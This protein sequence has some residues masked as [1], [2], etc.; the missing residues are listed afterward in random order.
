MATR[1]PW[2]SSV[3]ITATLQLSHSR[4]H[5]NESGD[6]I[7]ILYFES[8]A[9]LHIALVLLHQDKAEPPRPAVY[10]AYIL[11]SSDFSL[12]SYNNMSSKSLP[13]PKPALPVHREWFEEELFGCRVFLLDCCQ[14]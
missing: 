9:T 12:Q 1:H 3:C 6:W 13:E 2:I 10:R 5:E 7:G 14:S 8:R 4:G 11:K